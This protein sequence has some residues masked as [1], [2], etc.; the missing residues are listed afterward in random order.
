MA[1]LAMTDLA[2]QRVL[3]LERREFAEM[4]EETRH[5]KGGK[6]GITHDHETVP[7]KPLVDWL[8]EENLSHVK[9]ASILSKSPSAVTAWVNKGK[10]PGIVLLALEGLKRRRRAVKDKQGIYLVSIPKDKVEMF[11][12]MCIMLAVK[13]LEVPN[14]E[15]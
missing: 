10:M 12:N 8:R 1:Q 7:S 13:P 4:N 9:A 5:V 15:E 14:A 6:T 11:T 3:Q 2:I